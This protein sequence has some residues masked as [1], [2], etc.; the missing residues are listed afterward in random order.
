MIAPAR[1]GLSPA[2]GR[3]RSG[4]TGPL[5]VPAALIADPLGLAI[6]PLTFVDELR[7]RIIRLG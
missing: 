4:G 5:A 3:S 6:T 7:P 2:V 1:G